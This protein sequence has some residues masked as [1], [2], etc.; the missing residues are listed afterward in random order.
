[1]RHSKYKSHPY[2]KCVVTVTET[3]ELTHSLSGYFL[4][5]PNLPKQNTHTSKPIHTCIHIRDTTI[6]Y[7]MHIPLP[8]RKVPI[9]S[10][11]AKLILEHINTV[12]YKVCL[13]LDTK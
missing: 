12:P 9:V 10:R 4:S 5:L 6:I 3:T 2:I 8:T 13:C 1:M 7:F 11:Y